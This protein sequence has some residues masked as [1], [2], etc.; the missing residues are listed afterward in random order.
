V[1]AVVIWPMAAWGDCPI[2][3]EMGPLLAAADKVTFVWPAAPAA[4]SYAVVRG[5]T[6]ALP[7]GPGG[8]DEIC[9]AGLA[10][11][12]IVDAEVPAPGTAFWYLARGDNAC[13]YGPYGQ[14]TG[15]S[16]RITTTCPTPAFFQ[17]DV[18]ATGFDLPT[19]LE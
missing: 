7:V 15:G 10:V 3:S 19:N 13:G 9:F 5:R 2:P 8:S 17:N 11:P 12:S 16:P 14:R 6:G 4:T 18:L 1:L